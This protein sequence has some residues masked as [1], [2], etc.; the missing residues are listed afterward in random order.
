MVAFLG[1]GLS[2]L[3][4]PA[5][6]TSELNVLFVPQITSATHSHLHKS[7]VMSFTELSKSLE[8]SESILPMFSPDLVEVKFFTRSFEKNQLEMQSRHPK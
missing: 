2:L 1:I 4:R 7:P 8:S 5:L 6:V 3:E